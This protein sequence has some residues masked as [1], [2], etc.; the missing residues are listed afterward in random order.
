MAATAPPPK[1]GLLRGLI[2]NCTLTN[3]N[4]FFKIVKK[5]QRHKWLMN[6][7]LSAIIAIRFNPYRPSDD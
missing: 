7:Q 6:Q 2:L 5:W 3:I 1:S 4:R